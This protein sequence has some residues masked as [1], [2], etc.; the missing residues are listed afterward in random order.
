MDNALTDLKQGIASRTDWLFSTEQGH[1]ALTLVIAFVM[2]CIV[3]QVF[4]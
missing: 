1:K 3:G 4:A 2:G